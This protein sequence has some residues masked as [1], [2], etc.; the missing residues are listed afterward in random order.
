MNIRPT[1]PGQTQGSAADRLKETAHDPSAP[2][3]RPV[4]PGLQPPAAD[5][6]ELSDAARELQQRTPIEPSGVS[7]LP[8]ERMGELLQRISRGFYDRPEVRDEIL[9]RLSDDLESG[10][11]SS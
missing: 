10:P 3:S 4:A 9:R 8:R 2:K 1:Q 5:Q 6:V 11:E 7:S